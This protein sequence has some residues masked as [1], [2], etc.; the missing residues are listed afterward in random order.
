M[1]PYQGMPNDVVQRKKAFE[2]AKRVNVLQD[3]FQRMI[4]FTKHESLLVQP[5]ALHVNESSGVIGRKEAV[6]KVCQ[7][8]GLASL[9][10]LLCTFHK[11]D[12]R[13]I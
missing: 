13:N 9:L 8:E 5:I 4:V 6:T 3:I 10:V 2:L 11:L 7:E 1:V 12:T